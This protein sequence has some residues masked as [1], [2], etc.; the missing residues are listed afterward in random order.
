MAIASCFS[1]WAM[2]IAQRPSPCV[3]SFEGVMQP[4]QPTRDPGGHEVFIGYVPAFR[5]VGDWR[6]VFGQQR[7]SRKGIVIRRVI[8][9]CK[10]NPDCRI[11]VDVAESSTGE[12]A[13]TQLETMTRD[14]NVQFTPGPAEWA[15]P[16]SR[17]YP[18]TQPYSVHFSRANLT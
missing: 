3:R 9:E 2:A 6:P 14:S 10:A 16:L 8:W 13:R 7:P 17:V 12:A 4:T 15:P 18:A 11:L 1:K 5:N